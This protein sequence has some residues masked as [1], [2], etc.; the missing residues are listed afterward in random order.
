MKTMNPNVVMFVGRI[1]A[2]FVTLSM[3]MVFRLPLGPTKGAKCCA[4]LGCNIMTLT[5]VS[6]NSS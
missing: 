3:V 1:V 2:L 5:C 4:P 6:Q